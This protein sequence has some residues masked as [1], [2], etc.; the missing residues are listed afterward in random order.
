MSSKRGYGEPPGPRPKPESELR[1]EERARLARDLHDGTA[2]LLVLL[3]LQLARLKRLS[4]PEV[5]ALAQEC[6]QTIRE[7]HEHIRAIASD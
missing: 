7:M 3:Q 1:S 5:A 2:Q 6:E 4:T